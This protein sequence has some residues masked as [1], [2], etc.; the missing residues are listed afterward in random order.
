MIPT[1]LHNYNCFFFKKKKA[2]NE[3]AFP[4]QHPIATTA[5]G[6]GCTQRLCDGNWK[7]FSSRG[8]AVKAQQ[9]NRVSVCHAGIVCSAGNEGRL[10]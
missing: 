6:V 7:Q 3:K 8:K 9:Q 10:R 4:H 5:L 1:S 2:K